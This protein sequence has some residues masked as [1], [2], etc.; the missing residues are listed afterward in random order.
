MNVVNSQS[1]SI[2]R[3]IEAGDEYIEIETSAN[4]DHFWVPVSLVKD[5]SNEEVCLAGS[6]DDL[7][8]RWLN[9]D[10]DAFKEAMVDE[11]LE[12]TFPGSDPPSFNPQKS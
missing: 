8:S 12:E 4:G 9:K 10:P 5:T 11:A 1:E 3:V 6:G 2:G 7:S